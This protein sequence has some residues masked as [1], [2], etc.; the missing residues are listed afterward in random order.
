[1][2]EDDL[3]TRIG[4]ED[5]AQHET[6]ALGRGFDGEAPGGAQQ[7]GILLHILLV[8][9]LDDGGVGQCG[10]HV[11]RH[12]ER[13]RP[14]EDRPEPFVVEKKPVGQTVHQRA[15]EAQ[16]GDRPFEFVG[17]SF[18]IRS[19]KRSKGRE[20]VGVGADLL[21]EPV[22][23]AVRQPDGGLRVELLQTGVGMRQHLHVDAGLVHFS[24]AQVADIVEPLDDPRRIGRLLADGVTLHLGIEIMLLQ[25]NDVRLRGHCAPP[26]MRDR[27]ARFYQAR[28]N[29]SCGSRSKLQ[30]EQPFGVAAQQFLLVLGAQWQGFRPF[31]RRRIIDERIVDG[32]QDPVDPHFHHAAQ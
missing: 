24:E 5:A 6:Q 14:L 20:P 8:V 32:E 17:G 21:V 12:V 30:L 26:R 13:L 25:G 10:M 19:G 28:V 15:L 9:S 31:R 18:R 23:G 3:E 16:F 4:V 2:A 27:F 1:V 29:L 7:R 22:V 11:E